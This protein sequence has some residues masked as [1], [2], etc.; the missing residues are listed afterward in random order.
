MASA[1]PR[2]QDFLAIDCEATG[3]RKGDVFFAFGLYCNRMA[4]RFTLKLGKHPGES[5]QELWTRKG[6]CMKTY[7]EFWQHHLA[8]LDELEKSARYTSL[9]ELASAIDT[10]LVELCETTDLLGIVSDT[11]TFD[12][13]A[14]GSLL[15]EHGHRPLHECRRTGQYIRGFHTDSYARGLFNVLPLQKANCDVSTHLQT[16]GVV[17]SHLP[18]QDAEFHHAQ[19]AKIVSLIKQSTAIV[20]SPYF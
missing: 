7:F 1:S 2:N 13:H 5:W 12:G 8:V 10:Y 18:E 20:G 19:F 16:Y 6:Y 14:L 3:C 11:V 9:E 15:R 17:H 4:A